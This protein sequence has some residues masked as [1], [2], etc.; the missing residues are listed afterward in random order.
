MR[1]HT[2]K[3][4][5]TAPVGMLTDEGKETIKLYLE[6]LRYSLGFDLPKFDELASRL[7]EVQ[8]AS[9]GF[10]VYNFLTNEFGYFGAVFPCP[11]SFAQWSEPSHR[12]ANIKSVLKKWHRALYDRMLAV[13]V[14]YHLD[15]EP[16]GDEWQ[17]SKGTYPKRL[18][19]YLKSQY[20][21]KLDTRHIETIGNIGA[22]YVSRKSEYVL[23]FDRGFLTGDAKAYCNSGSC[24]FGTGSYSGSRQAL[25]DNGGYA[26]RV[27]EDGKPAARCWIAPH[28]GNHLIFNSYGL[29]LIEFAR[30][31]SQRNGLLYKRV[32]I[33][34]SDDSLYVN[35]N[36]GYI[37]G[38]D[39]STIDYVCLDW[40]CEPV[41]RCSNCGDGIHPDDS[42]CVDDESYCDYCYGELFATCDRCCESIPADDILN[43]DQSYYCQWCAEREG[44][45]RCDGCSEMRDDVISDIDLCQECACNQGFSD[46]HSCGEWTQDARDCGDEW[47]CPE[48]QEAKG[49]QE[50]KDCEDMKTD[51]S[52]LGYCPDCADKPAPNQLTLAL[53]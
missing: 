49:Y 25:Y 4:T 45:N 9:G 10:A 31:L 13:Q 18:A 11:P 22:A 17:N 38:E 24:W 28:E 1:Y 6:S 3:E 26:V 14:P 32:E 52:E 53:D 50:C 15:L 48:C 40:H 19:R 7:P 16:L 30:I 8:E 12:D 23:T 43:C 39:V 29:D 41:C 44:Y 33:E 35:G 34:T 2:E 51:C 46:C 37:I 36:Y 27:W 42:Y 21:A 20:N 5:Y 47:L